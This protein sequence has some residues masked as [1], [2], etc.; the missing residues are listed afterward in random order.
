MLRRGARFLARPRP[1]RPLRRLR[2]AGPGALPGC[3]A[4]AAGHGP[5][6]RPTPCPE[7]LAAVLRRVASTTGCSG[8]IVVAHKEH[9]AFALA[10]PLGRVLARCRDGRAWTRRRRRSSCR[11]PPVPPWCGRAVT[12]R[13]CASARAAA[14]RLRRERGRCVVVPG[15]CEQRVAVARPGGPGQRV[16]ARPTWPARCAVR[17]AVRRRLAS[18]AACPL[19]AG[20]LRRRADHRRHG[21][22][23]AAG[24]RGRRAAGALR[25]S[26]WPPPASGCCRRTCRS[27]PTNVRVGPITVST[28]GTTGPAVSRDPGRVDRPDG[29]A[30]RLAAPD[31]VRT[32]CVHARRASQSPTGCG[33]GRRGAHGRRGAAGRPDNRSMS[34]RARPRRATGGLRWMSSSAAGTVRCRTGSGSTWRRSSPGSRS[35]ITGSSGSRCCSRRRPRPR[36]PER[37][38]RVELTA[39]STG[40]DRAR[41]GVRGGQDGGPRPRAGQDGRADAPGR[42][43]AQGAPRPARARVARAGDGAVADA[44]TPRRADAAGARRPG[45]NGRPARGRPATDRSSSARR[46]T[47]PR[48]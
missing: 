15:C 21:A 16:S 38:V 30:E 26:R 39:K 28:W 5:S 12:T 40:P 41:R 32:R 8:A 29:S 3:D 1:R 43:P 4:P 46:P 27:G 19:L 9:A 23:G 2:R 48:R 11:C 45:R 42:R 24:A 7:G 37:A 33:A 20:G 13:C 25:W 17:P 35:T 10:R 44:T 31:G 14:R 36:D 6:V 22:G 18:A 34:S 47:R